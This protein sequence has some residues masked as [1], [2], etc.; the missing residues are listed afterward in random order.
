MEQGVHRHSGEQAA[1]RLAR[2]RRRAS[3]PAK[4]KS[5][6]SPAACRLSAPALRRTGQREIND[7]LRGCHHFAR[8]AWDKPATPLLQG[9]MPRELLSIPCSNKLA[10]RPVSRVLYGQGLA[11]LTWRPFILGRR[12]RL[13]R[14]TYPDTP[15]GKACSGFPRRGVPIRSCSRRGLPCRLRCRL[16]GGLLPHLFTLTAPSPG[17]RRRA[18]Q[19]LWHFP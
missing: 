15:A 5:S 8:E 4:A 1:M 12:C 13:P 18:V 3:R 2:R 11:P 7:I 17:G 6:Q 16:R 10:S 19:S 14:A 9:A